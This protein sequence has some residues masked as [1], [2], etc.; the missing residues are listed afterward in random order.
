MLADGDEDRQQPYTKTQT[1]VKL[2]MTS[3]VL[4]FLASAPKT[5]KAVV[6]HGIGKELRSEKL[7]F[8]SGPSFPEDYRMEERPVPV[9]GPGEVLVKVEAVGICAGDSKCFAGAARFWGKWL[10]VNV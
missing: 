3:S 9:P 8:C 1:W 10:P 6:I 4:K 2:N 7:P 5:M